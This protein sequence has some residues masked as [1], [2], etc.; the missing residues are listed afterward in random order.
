MIGLGTIIN[1][2]A[3]VLGGLLGLLFGRNVKVRYQDILMTA[4]GICVL[5]LGIGG[6]MEQ[7]LSIAEG[8]LTGG[9]SMMLIFTMALG[10]MAGYRRENGEIRLLAE[11]ENRQQGGQCLCGG[12]CNRIADSLHRSNGGG[13]FY[14]RRDFR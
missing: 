2:G 9:G 13:R 1:V 14:P 3:I 7:M 4:V 12:L 10:R 6:T 11:K 5:M 8:R